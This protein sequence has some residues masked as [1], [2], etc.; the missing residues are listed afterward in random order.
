MPNRDPAPVFV[1]RASALALALGA[2]GAWALGLGDLSSRSVLGENLVASVE[3]RA[4]SGEVPESACFSLRPG[5]DDSL[6][7]LR[8]GDLILRR[9]SPPV[10]EIRSRR[11]LRE[12]VLRIGILV[13]CGHDLRREYTLLPKPGEPA[14]ELVVAPLLRI[15]TDNAAPEPVREP[16]PRLPRPRVS[17]E[18]APERLA[19]ARPS[20]PPRST[21]LKDRLILSGGEGDGEPSLRLSTALSGPVA[22]D[23][24]REAEREL[25]RLEFRALAALH[26]Q[27]MSQLAAAEKLRKLE[28]S[29]GELQQKAGQLAERIEA[30]QA[31]PPPP[32]P[33]GLSTPSVGAVSAPLP[34]TPPAPRAK[35]VAVAPAADAAGEGVFWGLLLGAVAGLAGWLV[36][37]QRS[38][39]TAVAVADPLTIPEPLMDPPREDERDEPG[40]VDLAVEPAAMGMP[41]A[42]DLPLEEGEGSPAPAAAEPP[43]PRSLDSAFSISAASVHEHFEVNPVMELA[44]IMLSFGRV[45]GAAQALQEYIDQSPKEALQPW[46]KLLE[47]YRLA[48]MREEFERVASSLNQNFNVAVLNW[49]GDARPLSIDFDLDAALPEAPRRPLSLEELPHV[50]EALVA[51]WNTP[52]CGEYLQWLLR[53]N[54]GGQRSGFAL[55]VVEEILFLVELRETRERLE[56][57]EASG[58]A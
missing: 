36:W 56:R 53:D 4:S 38:R 49:E 11:P 18:A 39:R 30:R 41:F 52:E 37:R 26:E 2:P 48:N 6:P 7:W 54:R 44:E 31:I 47:V 14:G 45:K 29:L 51:A 19:P 22:D 24:R 21:P 3:L 15:D 46:I 33:T 32:A 16:R 34:Q 20:R 17:Q 12:P 27:A 42:V 55:P 58:Q 57:E 50:I 23:P 28:S 13:G 9:G 5:D 40:G 10:L 25:L 43:R 35:P 8:Q 1:L